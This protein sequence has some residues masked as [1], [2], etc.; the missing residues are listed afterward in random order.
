[1]RDLRQNKITAHEA[2][3]KLCAWGWKNN[4]IVI[5]M[6][7]EGYTVTNIPQHKVFGRKGHIEQMPPPP[8]PGPE[9][10][11]GALIIPLPG[12]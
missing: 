10:T 2:V 9:K 5:F 7:A 11:R 1:M 3:E 4:S 8:P 12:V 6:R